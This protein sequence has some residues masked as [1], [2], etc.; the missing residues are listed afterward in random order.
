MHTIDEINKVYFFILPT[1]R[2][3][4]STA[5]HKFRHH[6]EVRSRSCCHVA[7]AR[8]SFIIVC[9]TRTLAK[10]NVFTINRTLIHI[11]FDGDCRHHERAKEKGMTTGELELY[12][13]R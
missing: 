6:S 10:V 8:K 5:K 9:A 13:T 4:S 3:S 11:C 1:K 2:C 12:E 7:V